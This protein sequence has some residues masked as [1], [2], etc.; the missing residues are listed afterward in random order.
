MLLPDWSQNEQQSTRYFNGRH[1]TAFIYQPD[2]VQ[3]LLNSAPE[4]ALRALDERFF[5]LRSEVTADVI[6]ILFHHWKANKSEALRGRAGITLRRICEYRDVIPTGDNLAITWRA[7]QDARAFRLTGGG[8]NDALFDMA[9]VSLS[10][11]DGVPDKDEI[12]LYQPGFLIQYGIKDQLYY[13]PFLENIWKLNAH[14]AGEAKRLARFLRGEWRLN[15]IKYLNPTKYPNHY[16]HT[17]RQI[18]SEAGIFPDNWENEKRNVARDIKRIEKAVEVLYE[19]EFI[20]EGGD[21]IYHPDDR[22]RL[23]NLPRKGRLAAW[24]ELRVRFLPAADIR[25]ALKEGEAK[26]RAHQERDEKALSTERARLKM[27]AEKKRKK[28]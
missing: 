24:L 18:L 10:G 9:S 27:N 1:N 8:I 22:Q 6:D 28:M 13:S 12:Y 26:H 19:E 3:E 20:A 23:Q 14:E 11:I 5:K 7:V 2:E 17:W 21:A 15:R 16:W 25:D 4:K